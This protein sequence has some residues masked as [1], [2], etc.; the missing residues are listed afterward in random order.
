M[1]SEVD[2]TNVLWEVGHLL[3]RPPRSSVERLKEREEAERSEQERRLEELQ[4]EQERLKQ[5]LA[6]AEIRCTDLEQTLSSKGIHE[7]VLVNPE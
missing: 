6:T 1:V 2:E 3:L 7:A 5:D 4:E